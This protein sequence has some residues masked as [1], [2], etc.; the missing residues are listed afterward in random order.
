M[1]RAVQDMF[2]EFEFREPGVGGR[3]HID[4]ASGTDDL[5]KGLL[6]AGEICEKWQKEVEAFRP[7]LK[8]YALYE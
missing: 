7:T 1:M 3:W 4:I 6:S 2:S 5:R 8:K